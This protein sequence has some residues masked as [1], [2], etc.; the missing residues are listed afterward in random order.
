MES[1]LEQAM[2]YKLNLDLWPR[3]FIIGC[4]NLA[5]KY[6]VNIDSLILSF[7][8]GTA[9]FLGKT[10]VRLQGSDRVEVG[11]LWILNVQVKRNVTIRIPKIHWLS[12]ILPV[13][14]AKLLLWSK[15]DTF[16]AVT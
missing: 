7:L 9:T 14:I 1:P 10:Q 11:S 5:A 2:N 4:S 16:I 3:D 15:I 6:R 12:G 13:T 8:L